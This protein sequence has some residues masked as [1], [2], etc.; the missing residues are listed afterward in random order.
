[1]TISTNAALSSKLIWEE[2]C[3]ERVKRSLALGELT[4]RGDVIEA[5]VVV[6][7]AGVSGL[8]AAAA[9]ASAGAKTI[10]LERSP[11]AA[12]G[13]SGRNAGIVCMGANLLRCELGEDSSHD[14][15]WKET[16]TLAMD[17]YDAA[18]QPDSFVN[19]RRC[20]S[21]SFAA[22]AEDGE[23]FDEEIRFRRAMGLE[24]A[25]ATTDEV[26]TM[27]RGR[28]AADGVAKTLW[29]PDEGRCHPWTLCALLAERARKAG[30]TMYGGAHVINCQEADDRWQL[31]LESG[32]KVV[33]RGLIRGTGPTVDANKRIYAMA[34]ETSLPAEFPVF[35]DAAPFT[36]FDYRTGDG[37]IVCTGGPYGT[38]GDTAADSAYFKTMADTVRK[39]IPELANDEPKYLWA[40]DLKV[41]PDM[42]P[43]ILDLKDKGAPGFAIVGLGALGVLPGIL[44]GR[45]AA[46]KLVSTISD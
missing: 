35:Q 33:A 21:L 34:F 39:W 4:G 31:V 14:W 40:V 37:H 44:L 29:L 1:M 3:D 42:M 16:T 23:C 19:A 18:A 27:T 2:T 25:L 6:I 38:A 17:V 8:S 7:G 26:R 45:K 46:Q 36:Y 43:Q 9:A 30:A 32:Q 10:L 22:R 11:R 28:L 20:G 41:T 12:A 24:A 15:L 13:A 5:D